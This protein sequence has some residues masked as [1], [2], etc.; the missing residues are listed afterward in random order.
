ML[1]CAFGLNGFVRGS[2]FVFVEVL[3]SVLVD[4]F[5]GCV[6]IIGAL[7]HGRFEELVVVELTVSV[8]IVFG[9]A[10]TR[11][12][13]PSFGSFAATRVVVGARAEEEGGGGEEGCS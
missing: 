1:P 11:A 6:G 2:E 8:E 9:E 12:F 10:L 13:A 7:G 4:A 5:E 3:V